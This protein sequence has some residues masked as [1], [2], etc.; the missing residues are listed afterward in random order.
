[1]MTPL[2]NVDEDK[3]N[4]RLNDG[5]VDPAGRLLAGTMAKE[6]PD[7]Q[8]ERK[9]GSLYSVN[10]DLTVTKLLSQVDISNGLEWS[11]DQRTFF[12]IDSLSLTVDAFDYEQTSGS[13]A[14]RRV[15]YQMKEG[16]G[17]PDGM[18]IDV[19]GRLWVA[20]YNGGRVINIDPT[21]G[22]R[23]QTISLPVTKVTSCCF[24]GPDFSDLFVTSASLGLDQSEQSQQPLAGNTFRVRGLGVKGQPSKPFLG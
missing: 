24:G 3:L 1:M 8:L 7:V 21:T 23:L 20:C 6:K 19:D 22:V 11:L 15:V 12:Y 4:T 14:N 5:K 10:S 13:L 9:Q 16:E 17:L 18:A 2:A